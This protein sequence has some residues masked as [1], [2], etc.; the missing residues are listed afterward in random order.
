MVLVM[1]AFVFKG[2]SCVA[3][4]LG[5]ALAAASHAE[6]D[7]AYTPIP[8]AP[9]PWQDADPNF[10]A[11]VDKIDALVTVQDL[12]GLAE[13]LSDAF[14][15]DNDRN[16]VFDPEAGARANF[17]AA[18]HLD[19]DD[20]PT[21][22]E[23]YGWG[24]LSILLRARSYEV[25]VRDNGTVVCGPARPPHAAITL[26]QAVAPNK[27]P[28]YWAVATGRSLIVREKPDADS[29][30]VATVSDEAVLVEEWSDGASARV[31][32]RTPEGDVGYVNPDRLVA[33]ANK[34]L[35]FANTPTDGWIIAGAIGG[36]IGA[37][38]SDSGG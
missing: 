16:K 21:G 27:F 17:V 11:A 34:Q 25:V 18:M 3:L 24:E 5:G 15:F 6:A 37:G 35:C 28:Y 33:I 23:T 31:K 38:V 32:I 4:L 26:M 9:Q 19:P 20:Q 29:D 8:I 13:H 14:F 1:N 12:D 30:P 36:G 10:A 7:R 22:F 2:L